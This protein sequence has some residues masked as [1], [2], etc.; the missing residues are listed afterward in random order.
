MER[1]AEKYDAMA[2]GDYSGM[3]RKEMAEAVIDVSS[4]F[5]SA[6]LV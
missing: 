4:L 3:S 1:K 6:D 2:K 5:T